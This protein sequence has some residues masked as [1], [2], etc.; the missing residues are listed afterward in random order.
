MLLRDFLL[1]AAARIDLWRRRLE[2]AQLVR[3]F[4]PRPA[5]FWPAL[6]LLS[7]GVALFLAK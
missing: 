6:L 1:T 3:E 2:F 4:P 7:L 5:A